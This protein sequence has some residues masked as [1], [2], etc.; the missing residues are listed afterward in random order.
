MRIVDD[1]KKINIRKDEKKLYA[2]P[3]AEDFDAIVPANEPT[4]E[5]YSRD[6]LIEQ[7]DS[8]LVRMS[9]SHPACNP[10]CYTLLHLTGQPGRSP[11]EKFRV[12]SNK[13]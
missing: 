9:E 11:E 3:E 1:F 8:K 4:A 5:T 7:I 10:L 13:K 6:I 12:G 2:L